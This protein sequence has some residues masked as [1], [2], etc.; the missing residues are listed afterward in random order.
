MSPHYQVFNPLEDEGW[1]D[2]LALFSDATF[3]HTQSWA[4]VL[5][6]TYGY[7]PKYFLFY[8]EH[9]PCLLLPL[10][11]IKSALTGRRG[12]S[13]PFTD[14]MLPLVMAPLDQE[15]YWDE[16]IAYA[17]KS[18][19]RH[20]DLRGDL[21]FQSSVSVYDSFMQHDI[22]LLDDT[23]EMFSRFSTNN[24]RNIK[25]AIREDVEVEIRHD[26]ES[27][28]A[29]Y[30]LNSVTRKRH[31]VPSQPFSFFENLLK[32][33]VGEGKGAVVLAKKQ[34]EIIAGAIYFLFRDKAIYKYGASKREKSYLRANNLIMWEAIKWLSKRGCKSLSLGR[35]EKNNEGLLRYKMGWAPVQKTVNYYR[36]S[37][38]EKMFILKNDK[39]ESVSA[40][41]FKVAPV[42]LSNFLGQ[43]LYK[44]VG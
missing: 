23:E 31:G 28:E 37:L 36:Y 17:K 11:E 34:E 27:V 25:K 3:F 32:Y 21:G 15:E 5:T 33:I 20:I 39:A 42:P 6:K 4:K 12:V 40:N 19:W 35:T 8:S 41:F 18:K 9:K 38:K 26:M 2:L 29:F 7:G 43:I 24:K 10:M 30:K 14:F 13:L 44:H 22:G 1:D 16:L